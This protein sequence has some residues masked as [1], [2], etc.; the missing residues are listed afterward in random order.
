VLAL[1]SALPAAETVAIMMRI[2]RT[3]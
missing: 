1:R 2:D 3:M